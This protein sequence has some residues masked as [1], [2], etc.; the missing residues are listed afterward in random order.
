[1]LSYTEGDVVILD[2]MN[3]LLVEDEMDAP[4][5]WDAGTITFDP[6]I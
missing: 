1:M 3:T 6:Y 4:K 2:E 5:D